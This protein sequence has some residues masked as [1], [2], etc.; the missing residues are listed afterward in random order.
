MS[1]NEYQRLHY[2]SM[3]GKPKQTAKKEYA[4]FDNGQKGPVGPYALL[5]HLKNEKIKNGT[6]AYLLKIKPI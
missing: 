2:Q 6:P 5:Q 1:Y 3:Y 4:L